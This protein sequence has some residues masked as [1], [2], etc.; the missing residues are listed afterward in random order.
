[1]EVAYTST[2]ALNE[3]NRLNV[4]RLQQQLLQAQQEVSTGRHYD[5]GQTLGS[6]T[7]DTVSLRQQ[8]ARY[9]TL[10]DTNSVVETRL[11]SSQAVLADTLTVANQFVASMLVARDADGGAAVARQKAE[12]SLVSLTDGLNTTVGGEYLFGGTNNSTRPVADYFST[13]TSAARTAVNTAFTT[14]FGTTQSDP[15]NGNIT[16]S[17]LQTFL[18][19]AFSA[20]F[21][22]TDWSA[23]WSSASNRNTVSRISLTEE[24]VSSANANESPFRKLAEAYTMVADLGAENLSEATFATLTDTAVRLAS[25]AI[26][27]LTVVQGR[28]GSSAERVAQSNERMTAQRNILNTQIDNLERVDPFEASTRVTTLFTQLQTSY[29]LTARVQQLTILNYLAP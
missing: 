27:E 29:A 20:M 21:D 6:R 22:P 14:A 10:I 15:A 24:V 25:E 28:L 26:Q 1:M 23:N 19:T 17:A 9:T 13:P 3:G 8:Y 18:D 5:V 2:K 4:L 12:A 7:A 16:P 11:N